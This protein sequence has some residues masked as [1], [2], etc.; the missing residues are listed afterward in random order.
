M[1]SAPNF[2]S[3]VVH[4]QRYDSLDNMIVTILISYVR[5]HHHL[6]QFIYKLKML[7]STS[8]KY[9][10]F[11]CNSKYHRILYTRTKSM[12]SFEVQH[13]CCILCALSAIKLKKK[14]FF[15]QKQSGMTI[16]KPMKST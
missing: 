6:E 4:I 10:F 8:F 2:Q 5:N 14:K 1:K 13:G 7:V 11:K 16:I 15:G 12:I 3:S 9:I